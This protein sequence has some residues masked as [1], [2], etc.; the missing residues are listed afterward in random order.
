MIN[1]ILPQEAERILWSLGGSVGAVLSFAF[2]DVGA[3]L[4]WLTIFAFCDLVLG[5]WVAARQGLWNSHKVFVGVAKKTIMFL[6]VALSHGLDEAFKPI[7]HIQIFQ[8]ITIC[9][10]MAGEFGSIIETLE[11]GGFGSVIPPV[12]RR[13]VQGV[14]DKLDDKVDDH[15]DT[16][17]GKK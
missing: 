13:I 5:M 1:L 4:I 8:S 6:I 12:L 9:A 14:N 17:G 2:G 16:L 11:R 3:L 10:Y 15:L 7:I